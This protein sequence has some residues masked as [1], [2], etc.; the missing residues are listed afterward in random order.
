MKDIMD[1][2]ATLRASLEQQYLSQRQAKEV[3]ESLDEV[4]Q[5]AE[6][7]AEGVSQ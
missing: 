2:I 6:F 7:L 5:V 1:Q 3:L 4:V